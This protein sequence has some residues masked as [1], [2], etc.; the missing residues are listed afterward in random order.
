MRQIIITAIALIMSVG[1]FAQNIQLPTPVK[2]GGKSLREALGMRQS[3]REFALN[4]PLIR[5]QLADLLWCTWGYNR[6]DKRT[7]PSCKN[8]QEIDVYVLMDNGSYRYDAKKN[9]LFQVSKDD[10]RRQSGRQDF[11]ATASLNLVYVC[12]KDRTD[13]EDEQS[14]MQATYADTGLIAQNAYLYCAAEG[15]NCV[16]RGY[17]QKEELSKVLG[18]N[19]NQI[20]TLAQTIGFPN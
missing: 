15:L 3:N 4:K 7:A 13:A 10:L 17:I 18:L 8:W 1:V 5:Q 14:L 2:K 11:V 16:V 6:P 19:N 9:V 12:N 20:I